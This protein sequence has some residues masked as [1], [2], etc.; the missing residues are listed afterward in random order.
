MSRIF[1]SGDRAVLVGTDY[2]R[3]VAAEYR[4]GRIPEFRVLNG[5][6]EAQWTARVQTG[7]GRVVA[8]P[9]QRTE[10][11]V[12]PQR[13]EPQHFGA[14][15]RFTLALEGQKGLVVLQQAG[16]RVKRYALPQPSYEEF[17]KARPGRVK[18]GYIR[19]GTQMNDE[20]G[21]WQVADGTLWFGKTF[22]DGEGMTGV[23]GFGYFDPALRKYRIYSPPEIADWSVTAILVEPD[24]VWLGLARRGEGFSA[25]GGLLRFHRAT[26]QVEKLE[27]R[28]IAGQIARVGDH[29]LIATEFGA[30]VAEEQSLRRFFLDRTTDGRLR[31]VEA[32]PAS[33]VHPATPIKTK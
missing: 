30:A 9:E 15:N 21:P 16:G 11:Y 14:N 32:T 19:T 2:R 31:I 1:V 24:D 33:P 3:L 12:Q 10:I 7:T 25:A 26:E 22:Y 28:D 29:L 23:G 18:D 27:R 17:A 8:G 5:A 4:P 6:E 13:F 20:I